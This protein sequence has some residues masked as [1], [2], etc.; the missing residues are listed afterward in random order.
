MTVT[1]ESSLTWHWTVSATAK[2]MT[3]GVQG[4]IYPIKVDD[5][6]SLSGAQTGT[7]HTATAITDPGSTRGK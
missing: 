1:D 2:V 5:T 4:N 6:V 3:D 7:L